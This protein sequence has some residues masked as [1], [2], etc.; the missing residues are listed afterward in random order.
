[1]ETAGEC[2]LMDSENPEAILAE[3][4]RDEERARETY[5]HCM[6]VS[7]DPA[8]KVLFSGLAA[9]EDS[10]AAKL[11]NLVELVKILRQ[12][13]NDA[14]QAALIDPLTGLGNRRFFNRALEDELNRADRHGSG[15]GLLL[16]DLDDFKSVNDG[17]GHMLGDALLSGVAETIARQVRRGVDL[18][19]RWGGEEFAIVSADQDREGLRA[20]AEKIRS[21]IETYSV[22]AGD[23]KTASVSASIGAALYPPDGN[24]VEELLRAADAALYAAKTSGRNKTVLIPDIPTNE[25]EQ[26][27]E[28][29]DDV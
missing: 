28:T 2:P 11:R 14:E 4:I 7:T 5:L 18:V 20:L 15:L 12:Q 24:S 16:L 6:E 26:K 8:L 23:G 9:D 13:A 17:H 10:H 3:A 21:S 25:G 22:L 29:E 19:F 1:M 27:Q